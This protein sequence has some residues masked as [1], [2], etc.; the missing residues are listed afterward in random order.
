VKRFL[1]AIMA[2][3][4]VF[5]VAFA[6]AATLNVN[7]GTIQAGEDNSVTCT[8]TASVAGWGYE[9]DDGMVY[10]VRI[11]VANDCAGNDMFV[12][13]TGAGDTTLDNSGAV[14]LTD[15]GNCT[16]PGGSICTRV[17][18]DSPLAP[19]DIEDIHIVIEGPGGTPND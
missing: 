12:T 8:D 2:G 11:F 19:A 3:A 17:Q 13:V 14:A 15:P 10:N 9:A 18:F 1:V 7:G 4:M 16:A 6:A 5:A